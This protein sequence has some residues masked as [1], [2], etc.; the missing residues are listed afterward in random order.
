MMELH[1]KLLMS[2]LAASDKFKEMTEKEK[3]KT[4]EKTRK[5]LNYVVELCKVGKNTIDLLIVFWILQTALVT[6][7]DWLVPVDYLANITKPKKRKKSKP[8]K[9]S[10]IG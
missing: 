8:K 6:V 10:Y 9:L 7:A 3:R 4:Y 1:T 2:Q 5:L